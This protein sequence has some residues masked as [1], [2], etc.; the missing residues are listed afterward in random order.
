MCKGWFYHLLHNGWRLICGEVKDQ[1]GERGA[2]IQRE[3]DPLKGGHAPF[4]YRL[5]K[6]KFENLKMKSNV[7]NLLILY[8]KMFVFIFNKCIYLSQMSCATNFTTPIS[9]KK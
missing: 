8:L 4:I 1:Q 3:R 5:D 2:D 9:I 6:R 7:F